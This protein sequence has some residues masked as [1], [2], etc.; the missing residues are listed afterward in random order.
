MR[1][2][3]DDNALV[4]RDDFRFVI[5]LRTDQLA[6]R[7]WIETTS[8]LLEACVAQHQAIYLLCAKLITLDK[9]F[10][11]SES[12]LPWQAILKGEAAIAACKEATSLSSSR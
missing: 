1:G 9:N 5:S 3:L 11:P 2:F 12:G 6:Q 8:A 4:G 7:I 10:Y